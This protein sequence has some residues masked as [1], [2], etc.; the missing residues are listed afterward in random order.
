MQKEPLT[1]LTNIPWVRWIDRTQIPF[2][3]IGLIA[4]LVFVPFYDF[5]ALTPRMPLQGAAFPPAFALALMFLIQLTRGANNDLRQL[6]IAGKIEQ[7]ALVSLAAGKNAARIELA[8]G[9]LIGADRVYSQINFDQ[10]VQHTLS[11]MLTP[12]VLAVCFS[13]VAYTVVQVHLLT[14]CVRQVIVFRRIASTFEVDLMVPELHNAMSNPLIRFIVVGLIA[15]SFGLLV[16]EIIPYVSLQRRVL[17]GAL[18]ALLVWMILIVVSLIP[19]FILKSRIA[20]A[21]SMEINAIRQ[22]LSGDPAGAKFSR[23]GPR[24]AEFTP[25][26]LMFYE[27][28]VKNVWEWPFEA[29]IRRLVIFGLLPPLTWVLA[30]AVEV[31]FET[32][33]IS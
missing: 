22:V 28:R 19:L 7:D 2:V 25:A 4:F 32:L 15:V 8:I 18:I 20:V 1:P 10:G 14:F 11:D 33:I 6:V 30:A 3:V 26:D 12:A 23:F 27:D 21:K 9:L 17:S 31:V 13:I 24:L 29:H 16:Y 5:N